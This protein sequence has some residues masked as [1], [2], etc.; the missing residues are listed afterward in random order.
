[1]EG[2]QGKEGKRVEELREEKNERDRHTESMRHF[3]RER[4]GGIKWRNARNESERKSEKS[5]RDKTKNL[6]L[7]LDELAHV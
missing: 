4:R 1:M 5:K 6:L 7:K 3:C 2:E